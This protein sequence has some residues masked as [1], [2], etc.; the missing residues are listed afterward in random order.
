MGAK[1][2]CKEIVGNLRLHLSLANIAAQLLCC[3]LPKVS[4]RGEGAKVVNESGESGGNGGDGNFVVFVQQQRQHIPL[5]QKLTRDRAF[6]NPY[7]TN[8]I[9]GLFTVNPTKSETFSLK[10]KNSSINLKQ[11]KIVTF[12][13]GKMKFTGN[14]LLIYVGG[15]DGKNESEIAFKLPF[16]GKPVAHGHIPLWQFYGQQLQ[17]TPS[18]QKMILILVQSLYD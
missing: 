5:T 11:P 7:A 8:A 9:Q 2:L 15:Q 13:H 1:V 6:I 16:R 3:P 10:S 14:F 12:F 4:Q 17:G 18:S